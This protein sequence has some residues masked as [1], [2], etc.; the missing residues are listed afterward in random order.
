VIER[1]TPDGTVTDFPIP[2]HE[3]FPS[4]F[5]ELDPSR[6]TITAGPDGNIWFSDP[7]AN[8]IG[9]I[10][11]DGTVTEYAVPTPD[12]FPAG[13]T[14][15]PDGNIWFTE[16]GSGQIG[17][18]ILDGG[19]SA[20]GIA[21]LGQAARSVA[22]DSLFAAAPPQLFMPVAAIRQTA[23]AVDSAFASS[24]LAGDIVTTGPLAHVETGGMF[25]SHQENQVVMHDADGLIDCL[26]GVL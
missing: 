19:G 8:Q 21:A 15:G 16:L 23:I 4:S 3:P 11:P 5:P 22:I 24:A 7:Y 1:I 13:I 26:T 9:N 25:H 17:E 18:F 20:P 14:T 2:A 6:M 12:S 10:A